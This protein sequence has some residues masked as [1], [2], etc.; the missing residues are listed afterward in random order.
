MKEK[1][2]FLSEEEFTKWKLSLIFWL[3]ILFH[4]LFILY[5]IFFIDINFFKDFLWIVLLCILIFWPFLVL[6]L[7]LTTG[8]EYLFARFWVNYYNENDEKYSETK[9]RSSLFQRK[10]FLIFS[11]ISYVLSVFFGIF[12]SRTIKEIKNISEVCRISYHQSYWITKLPE[13]DK[14]LVLESC[15]ENQEHQH[16]DKIISRFLINNPNICSFNSG[17]IDYAMTFYSDFEQ[18]KWFEQKRIWRTERTIERIKEIITDEINNCKRDVISKKI[19]LMDKDF[20]WN[21][22]TEYNELVKFQKRI[23]E[24]LEKK[25]EEIKS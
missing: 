23:N 1:K 8:I 11:I 4:T 2:R 3:W 15:T 16:L 14:N 7:L 22:W 20:D 25:L 19:Q 21:L 9:I 13:E 5:S 12:F 10:I 6:S 18:E 24:N 17:N